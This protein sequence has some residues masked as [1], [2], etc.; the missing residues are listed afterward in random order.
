M[1]A[2]VIVAAL[3][4]IIIVSAYGFTNSLPDISVTSPTPT[5]TLSASPSA[6]PT[7]T[8]N[9]TNTITPSATPTLLPATITPTSA[10]KSNSNVNSSSC[11]S[12]TINGKT[13]EGCV[14]NGDLDLHFED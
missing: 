9:D 8:E 3:F 5:P 10:Q 12:V 11:Y 1:T 13:Y 6:T 7:I 2:K 4:I 14:E